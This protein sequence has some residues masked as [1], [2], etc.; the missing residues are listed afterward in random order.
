MRWATRPGVHIDRAACAWLIGRHI[1]PHAE[2]VY[3]P[4]DQVLDVARQLGG[5]SYDA[6]GA[7][8]TH[9]ASRCT[10]EVAR[11][12]FIHDALYAWCRRHTGSDG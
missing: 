1:D 8:F 5:H 12:L 11:G 9:E 7:Q 2:F 6:R 3:V 4:T 10:F